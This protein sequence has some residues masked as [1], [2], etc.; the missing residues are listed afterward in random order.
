MPLEIRDFRTRKED[1]LTGSSSRLFFLDLQFHD[2]RGM[3]DHFGD[4]SDMTG[5]NFAKDTFN[6][7]DNS[8]YE[9]VS[10]LV[11]YSGR[12]KTEKKKKQTE[13]KKTHPEDTDC[14]E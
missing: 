6:D 8:S 10:L 1:I 7:P 3:L 11:V 12:E 5:P 9:P 13:K 2:I 4:V 14:V